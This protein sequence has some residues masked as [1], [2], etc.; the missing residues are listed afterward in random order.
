MGVEV[1]VE[2]Q[3]RFEGLD[4]GLI[5]SQSIKKVGQKFISMMTHHSF[6]IQDRSF[7]LFEE[8]KQEREKWALASA[9]WH[10]SQIF[11]L[12]GSTRILVAESLITWIQLHGDLTGFQNISD[13]SIPR[14]KKVSDE[15]MKHLFRAVVQGRLRFV[16]DILGKHSA[17][18]SDSQM[19]QMVRNCLKRIP[20][21]EKLEQPQLYLKKREAWRDQV[22][23][24]KKKIEE[25]IPEANLSPVLDILLGE[26]AALE[27]YSTNW[28]EFFVAKLFF[29]APQTS[30]YEA[31]SLP[32]Y[33]PVAAASCFFVLVF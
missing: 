25:N 13:P 16:S 21:A 15:F 3:Q 27:A 23:L 20:S 17:M 4:A 33:L 26:D 12:N 32:N 5:N 19:I 29:G 7:E 11:F 2:T 8:L 18:F 10:L 6:E 28:V 1:F 31:R 9:A 24:V 14:T 30:N 22:V